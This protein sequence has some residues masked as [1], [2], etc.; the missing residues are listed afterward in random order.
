MRKFIHM[1]AHWFNLNAGQVISA[2]DNKGNIWIAFQCGECGKI[3]DAHISRH[4]D[5]VP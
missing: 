3:Q 5:N 4:L 2:I 1:L